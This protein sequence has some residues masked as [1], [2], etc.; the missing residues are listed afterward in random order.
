MKE[1]EMRFSGEGEA[2]GYDFEQIAKSPYAYI[3]KKTHI[4]SGT[5]SYEVFRRKEN[6]QFDCISYPKSKSFGIWAYESNTEEQ[7]MIRFNEF[8]KKG[9][10]LC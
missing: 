2:R 6:T 9:M 5:V 4:E 8:N 1:L 10:S 3:Y 7:A